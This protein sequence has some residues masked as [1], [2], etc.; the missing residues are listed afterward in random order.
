MNA[1]SPAQGQASVL[2]GRHENRHDI[3]AAIG[4][5]TLRERVYAELRRCL[6]HGAFEAGAVLR[7]VDL[8]KTLQTSAMPVREGLGRLVSERA[9]EAMPNRSVRV[10]LISRPRLD[11]LA[12]ARRLVESE[13][14]ALALPSLDTADFAALRAHTAACERGLAERHA[15]TAHVAAGLDHAFH[16]HIYRAAG[17][18]VLMP[19]VESLWLQSGPYVRETATLRD[20]A[21]GR[22]A[23]RYHRLLIEALEAGDQARA[24]SA[25]TADITHS[26]SLIRAR[27]DEA[28]AHG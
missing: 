16:F 17:S 2:D 26:F 12:R 21:N 4:R 6:I 20:E 14:V 27:L 1:F 15:E 13:M 9:L 18:A 19:I 23:L 28:A 10:P 7:I 24:V 11:D 22:A 3:L 25:L 5:E 8:A